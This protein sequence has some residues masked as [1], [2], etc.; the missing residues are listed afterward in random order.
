[1][2]PRGLLW[3]LLL[4][5]RCADSTRRRGRLFR[6]AGS[7]PGADGLLGELLGGA[8]GRGDV[9]EGGDVALG[10]QGRGA[11][12]AGRGDRLPVVVV[13]E[14]ATREDARQVR[15]RRGVL[16]QHVPVVVE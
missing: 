13:D 11:A 4:R 10:V 15:V 1:S 9:V 2:F 6:C 5:G 16:H 14:V 7:E 8:G 3:L 12:G